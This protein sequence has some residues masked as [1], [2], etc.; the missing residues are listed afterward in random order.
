M[1]K[2]FSA[3]LND[4]LNREYRRGFDGASLLTLIAYYNTVDRFIPDEEKQAEFAREWEKELNRIV[5]EELKENINDA[6]EIA[7]YHIE[8]IRERYEMGEIT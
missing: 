8:K 1:G 7:A 6:A 4:K 2:K 3:V 5:T